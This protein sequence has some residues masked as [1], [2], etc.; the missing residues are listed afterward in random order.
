MKKQMIGVAAFAV[1]LVLFAFRS[2]DYDA[3]QIQALTQQVAEHELRLKKIEHAGPGSRS[4][5]STDAAPAHSMVLDS[6]SQSDHT[7]LIGAK[8]YAFRRR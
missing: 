6:I 1:V 3:Q 5:G 2:Q 4:H 8:L 7:L